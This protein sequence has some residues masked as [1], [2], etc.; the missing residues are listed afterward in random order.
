[1]RKTAEGSGSFCLWEGQ[2][3][4]VVYWYLEF[5][6]E[7]PTS[8]SFAILSVIDHLREKWETEKSG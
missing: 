7:N 5:Y 3:R 4:V 8:L 2:G 6:K 1:M